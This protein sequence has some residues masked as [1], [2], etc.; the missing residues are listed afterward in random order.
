MGACR[1]GGKCCYRWQECHIEGIAPMPAGGPLAASPFV[2]FQNWMAEAEKSELNDP[3]AMVVATATPDGR[4]S[5]RTILLKG[6]DE[7]GFVFYTNKESRKGGELAANP[8]VALL[9]YWKSLQRQIRIEGMVEHVTDAEADAYYRIA[10]ADFAPGRL[11]VTA[12]ASVGESNNS[13]GAAGG[14]GGALPR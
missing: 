13:G 3:N 6:V 2:Q 7:R 11:G 10:S 1:M 8:R 4:P 9:F 12:I 5:L 14:N